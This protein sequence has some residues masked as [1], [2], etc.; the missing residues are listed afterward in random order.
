MLLSFRDLLV[1]IRPA[2]LIAGFRTPAFAA[3]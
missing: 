1:F 3:E 2:A